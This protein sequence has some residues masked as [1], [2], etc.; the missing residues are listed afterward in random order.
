[1]NSQAH[2]LGT[3]VGVGTHVNWLVASLTVALP[4]SACQSH[5]GYDDFELFNDGVM[6]LECA[7]D[8]LQHAPRLVYRDIGAVF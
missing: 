6:C 8:T 4:S 5:L 1:M 2:I 7:E 3:W